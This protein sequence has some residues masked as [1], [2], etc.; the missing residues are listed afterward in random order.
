[1]L[2]YVTA[3]AVGLIAGGAVMYYIQPTVK[4]WVAR[5]FGWE[6][7]ATEYFERMAAAARDVQIK[8]AADIRKAQSKAQGRPPNT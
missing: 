6:G 4:I 1:M 7:D 5:A 3:T 8:L 2:G